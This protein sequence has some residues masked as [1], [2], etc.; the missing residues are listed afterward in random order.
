M[1]DCIV[2]HCTLLATN[3]YRDGD[4]SV[5][6]C[7]NHYDARPVLFRGE[8]RDPH[9]LIDELQHDLNLW[10]SNFIHAV[11][12]YDDLYSTLEHSWYVYFDDEHE[13]LHDLKELAE[14]FLEVEDS[15]Q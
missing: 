9:E 12:K 8:W 11:E 6:V 15:K 1:N 5:K 14:S 7:I 10:L 3:L 4:W 13:N 2:K